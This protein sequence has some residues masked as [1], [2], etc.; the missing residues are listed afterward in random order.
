MENKKDGTSN[1]R[2]TPGPWYTEELKIIANNGALVAIVNEEPYEKFQPKGV[3]SDANVRLIAAVPEI[4]KA[5]ED[6]ITAAEIIDGQDSPPA[7]DDVI[8]LHNVIAKARELL[9]RVL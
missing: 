8:Y 1:L 7:N 5:L 9:H 6:V 3:E 4:Y 2:H